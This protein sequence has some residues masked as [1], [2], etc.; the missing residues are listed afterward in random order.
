MDHSLVSNHAYF[1]VKSK[2]FVKLLVFDMPLILDIRY[3]YL[4]SCLENN[5]MNPAVV[6]WSGSVAKY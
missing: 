5:L 6:F 2:H 1:R 3:K 4:L